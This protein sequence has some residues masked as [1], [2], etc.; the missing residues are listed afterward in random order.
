MSRCVSKIHDC[1]TIRMLTFRFCP[2][3]EVLTRLRLLMTSVLRLI[4]RAVPCSLRNRP[5]AL[6]RTEPSSSRRHR[7]VVEVPQFW[8]TG[9]RLPRSW[10][11]KEAIVDNNHEGRAIRVEMW[12]DKGETA[13]KTSS[14][15]SGMFLYY[16]ASPTYRNVALSTTCCCRRRRR[17]YHA[18]THVAVCSVNSKLESARLS[19]P[20]VQWK[21]STVIA[22][23]MADEP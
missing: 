9:C 21:S 20:Q 5:Q 15:A 16:F 1:R 23:A 14:A 4:G 8:Q 18:L 2:C 3:A 17:V 11:A 22:R 12:P 19:S 10:L 13:A 6:Q 7:G